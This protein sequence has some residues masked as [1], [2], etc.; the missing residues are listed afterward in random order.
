MQLYFSSLDEGP[1]MRTQVCPTA[2]HTLGTR[3]HRAQTDTTTEDI[4]CKAR[5]EPLASSS[6]RVRT[7]MLA[8]HTS[9]D[10]ELALRKKCVGRSAPRAILVNARAVGNHEIPQKTLRQDVRTQPIIPRDPAHAAKA[11]FWKKNL[12]L[13][14]SICD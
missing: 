5:Q 14:A 1:R 4:S 13:K 7:D 11:K 2:P 8:A 12:L 9:L 6:A 10:T 3:R